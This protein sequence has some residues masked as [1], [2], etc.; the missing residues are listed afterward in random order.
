MPETDFVVR[1]L[2]ITYDG[3]FDLKE[4]ITHI[5]GWL[6]LSKFDYTEKEYKDILKEDK[7][8]IKI[9]LDCSKV[10]DEYLQ[11]TINITLKIK[12]HKIV[13]VKN[14][15]LVQGNL[16]IKLE[17]KLKSDYNSSW[18]G[19][20]LTKFVRGIYDKFVK[21]DIY[22]TYKK[23]IKEKTYELYNELKAYMNL[24]KV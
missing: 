16:T 3:V 20:P 1:D 15:N 2:K 24:H 11:K 9:E 17:S 7:R 6:D 12:D 10:I 4:I 14:K 13:Q 23:D 18:E 22:E 5:K 19:K 8:D 21:G